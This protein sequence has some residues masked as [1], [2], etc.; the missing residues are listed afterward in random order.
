MFHPS[1]FRNER[2]SPVTAWSMVALHFS[3]KATWAMYQFKCYKVSKAGEVP[4]L[5]WAGLSCYLLLLTC[6]LRL[7][8]VLAFLQNLF[9]LLFTVPP[10]Q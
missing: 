6:S 10:A 2:A 5:P 4:I 7:E 3:G 8:K 9:C 1:S